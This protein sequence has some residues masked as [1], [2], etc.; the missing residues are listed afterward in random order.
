MKQNNITF[1]PIFYLI[2]KELLRILE[3]CN[4]AWWTKRVVPWPSGVSWLRAGL[5]FY[6]V[7]RPAP[8]PEIWLSCLECDRTS[9]FWPLSVVDGKFRLHNKATRWV[10]WEKKMCKIFVCEHYSR[11]AS[12]WGSSSFVPARA[13]TRNCGA[14]SRN[15]ATEA[16]VT[17]PNHNRYLLN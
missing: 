15:P 4:L 11:R 3:V 2:A 7:S 16:S 1:N 9:A 12:A 14:F 6:C 8:A 5:G 10:L 13:A 17:L